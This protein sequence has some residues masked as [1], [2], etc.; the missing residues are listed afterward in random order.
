MQQVTERRVLLCRPPRPPPRRL[1]GCFRR[2]RCVVPASKWLRDLD[3]SPDSAALQEARALRE[4]KTLE[5]AQA[6]QDAKEKARL[7]RAAQQG[8]SSSKKPAKPAGG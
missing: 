2:R 7:R 8:Q 6:L 3:E 4:A 5:N 1:V